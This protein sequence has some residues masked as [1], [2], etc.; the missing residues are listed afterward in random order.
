MFQG[1]S[2]FVMS[3]CA[4]LD[5]FPSV[6]RGRLSDDGRIKHQSMSIWDLFVNSHLLQEESSLMRVDPMD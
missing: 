4:S 3:G 6:A 1:L 5:L 2:L